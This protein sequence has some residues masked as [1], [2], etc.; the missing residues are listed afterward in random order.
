MGGNDSNPAGNI[1]ATS[2]LDHY[3][4]RRDRRFA[5]SIVKVAKAPINAAMIGN[6]SCTR[7]STYVR[8]IER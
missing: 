7:P 3:R 8:F 1:R 4:T 2:D 5:S 6:Q